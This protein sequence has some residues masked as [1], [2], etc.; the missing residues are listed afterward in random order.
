MKKTITTTIIALALSV[1][2]LAAPAKKPKHSAEH[3]AAVKKCQADYQSAGTEAKTKKGK[4][5][6][7]ALTTARKARKDCLAAAPR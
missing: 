6:A 1:S 2:A 3:T 4:E 7:D 5:R